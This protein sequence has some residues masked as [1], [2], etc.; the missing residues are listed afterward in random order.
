[1]VDFIWLDLSIIAQIILDMT[2]DYGENNAKCR[3]WLWFALGMRT[4]NAIKI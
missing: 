2:S 1:M 3:Y 4:L